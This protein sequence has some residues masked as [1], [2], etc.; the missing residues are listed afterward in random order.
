MTRGSSKKKAEDAPT[1][2]ESEDIPSDET[3]AAGII[4]EYEETQQVE[5]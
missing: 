2:T 1:D 5:F 4:D 3:N